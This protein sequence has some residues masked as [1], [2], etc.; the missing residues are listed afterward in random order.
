MIPWHSKLPRRVY[1]APIWTIFIWME[2]GFNALSND[3]HI[4]YVLTK[5]KGCKRMMNSDLDN[6]LAPFGACRRKMTRR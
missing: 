1:S 3:I 6:E 2:R 4:S 5:E